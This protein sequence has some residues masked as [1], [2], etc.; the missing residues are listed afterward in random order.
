MEIYLVKGKV[1]KVL[2]VQAKSE[3]FKKQ[4]VIL[5]VTNPTDKGTF[6]EFI[7]LQCIN[8]KM[9]FLEGVKKGDFGICKF[10]ISG[11]KTGKDDDETFYTNLDVVDLKIVNK[12]ADIISADTK[13]QTNSYADRFPGI[14]EEEDI[15]S[16]E[17][18]PPKD[19][20][21]LPF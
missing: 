12:T 10:T 21:D 8:D 14:E 20:D 3:K 19:N 6:I 11:R 13:P 5:Q 16:S 4:E 9:N 2:P 18:I 7:R 1:Y 17:G 15:L